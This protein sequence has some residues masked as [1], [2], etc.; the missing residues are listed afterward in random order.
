MSEEIKAFNKL[1]VNTVEG[2]IYYMTHWDLPFR[3]K[4]LRSQVWNLRKKI[5]T[6]IKDFSKSQLVQTCAFFFLDGC[7]KIEKENPDFDHMESDLHVDD[8]IELLKIW[9]D[10]MEV[11]D[12]VW[13]DG[14]KP[15]R[16]DDVQ[17][18]K[19][20]LAELAEELEQKK[21]AAQ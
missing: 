19:E 1:L 10:S 16:A 20:A 14:E 9:N 7:D 15:I 5:Q 8:F 11:K 21:A 3:P 6:A 13:D 17:R 4:A 18:I 2:T 12:T